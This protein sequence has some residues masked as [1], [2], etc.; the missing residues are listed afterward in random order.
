MKKFILG[1][2]LI[3]ACCFIKATP[4]FALDY[5][6]VNNFSSLYSALRP[7]DSAVKLTSNI[8][9]TG[10]LFATNGT[11]LD[12]NGHTLNMAT[13]VF[14][15]LENTTILDSS[16]EKTGRING[17]A[18]FPIQIGN[19]T[20]TGN[21]TVESG[22]LYFTGNYGI[23]VM[24]GSSLAMD[25]GSI[26]AKHF[27]VYNQGTTTINDGE[28]RARN[29]ATIQNHTN[30]ILEINGGKIITDADYQ[31]INM[32]GSCKA[33][34]NGGEIIA[35]KEGTDY[36]GNGIMMFKD[37][38][39]IM[40]G[41]KITTFGAAI[42]G[43]GSVDGDNEGT[44]AKITITG[45]DI[46]ATS[47]TAIY[48]PQP[49]GVTTISGGTIEGTTAIEIRAG[50]L[51]ISGGTLTGT[52][53]TYDVIFNTN[54]STTTGAA[55]AIAQHTTK[56]PINVS[57]SG[58]NFTAPTALSFANPLG[59][60]E[61]DLEKITIEITGGN[62]NSTSAET[63]TMVEPREFITGGS[64]DEN[65]DE[66]VPDGYVVVEEGGR[67]VVKSAQ[68]LQ[69]VVTD[70]EDDESEIAVPNTGSIAKEDQGANL[71]HVFEPIALW[72]LMLAVSRKTGKMI[73]QKI[74]SE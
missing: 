2:I 4:T 21:L 69:P 12:L 33:T 59:N 65:I 1:T 28:V 48:I 73:A 53:D 51:N 50:T 38:E 61:E 44:N 36:M 68:S 26:S 49:N 17:T 32:Y 40:N 52:S 10:N 62:F 25:G 60:S 22:E 57:I 58:G 30:A 20:R 7:Q 67:F 5:V 8:T 71:F 66:F 70:P 47:D 39:F 74:T 29:N 56:L 55:V 41:G 24:G 37:T 46:K 42:L 63:I 35:M 34:M 9:A 11:T 16:A 31:A 23:R 19:S 45:G 18:S 13:N 15:V 27:T 43:N 14:V 72:V 6:E 64:F 3:I 54:G